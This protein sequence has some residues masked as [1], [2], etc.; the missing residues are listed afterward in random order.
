[1]STPTATSFCRQILALAESDEF[2][3]LSIEI[4]RPNE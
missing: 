4:R 2:A 3:Q 1:M